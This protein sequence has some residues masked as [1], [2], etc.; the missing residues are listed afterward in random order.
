M[1]MQRMHQSNAKLSHEY[2]WEK[3]AANDACAS[4]KLFPGQ[5]YDQETQLHYNYFRDYDPGTGRYMTS[6]PIGLAGGLN[7]YSYVSNNP[8]IFNDPFGLFCQFEPSGEEG[9]KLYTGKTKPFW[10]DITSTT[11]IL[12]CWTGTAGTPCVLWS[13]RYT[14]EGIRMREYRMRTKGKFVCYL[15]DDCKK[16]YEKSSEVS[17][18]RDSELSWDNSGGKISQSWYES[19]SDSGSDWGPDELPNNGAGPTPPPLV[20]IM[21]PF[22]PMPMPM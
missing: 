3:P 21:T 22:G 5:Y 12:P 7:T 2:Y 15:W 6:D 19:G 8:M 18:Y 17:S 13:T 20:P 16:K 4:G 9:I 11:V 10:G 1:E 14:Q